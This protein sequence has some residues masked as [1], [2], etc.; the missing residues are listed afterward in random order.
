MK[1]I[2]LVANLAILS[3]SCLIVSAKLTCHPN[4]PSISSVCRPL[5]NELE[6]FAHAYPARFA[7]VPISKA[8]FHLTP[9]SL[10]LKRKQSIISQKEFE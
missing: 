6:V 1:A 2:G 3:L 5:C 4:P 9:S 10:P 8:L 7:R